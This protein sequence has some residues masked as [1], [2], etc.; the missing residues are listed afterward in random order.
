MPS[1]SQCSPLSGFSASDE[2]TRL[3]REIPDH[4]LRSTRSDSSRFDS[5]SIEACGLLLDYSRHLVD[6]NIVSKLASIAEEAKL[7]EAIEAQFSGQNY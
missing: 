4:F 3:S 2:L 1:H 6:Q 5:F 7:S